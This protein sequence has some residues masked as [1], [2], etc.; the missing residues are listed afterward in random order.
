MIA[1]TFFKSLK[2]LLPTCEHKVTQHTHT[3]THSG[4]HA[5]QREQQIG[6]EIEIYGYLN[7]KP[8]MDFDESL[9][10]IYMYVHMYLCSL[11]CISS[12]FGDF[13]LFNFSSYESVSSSKRPNA[14]CRCRL[15]HI[16]ACNNN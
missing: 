11:V 15:S 9:S 3:R 16:C 6:I 8:L 12:S 2:I 1:N 4:Q 13:P 14:R 7:A 10:L 5:E